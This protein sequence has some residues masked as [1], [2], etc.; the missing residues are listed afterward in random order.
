VD[1]A[2]PAVTLDELLTGRPDELGIDLDPDQ[3]RTGRRLV[4]LDDD[5]TGTQT[6]VDL[7]VLTSWSVEDLRWALEQPTAGFFVLVNTRSLSPDDAATRNREVV[8][9]LHRAAGATGI[10]YAIASRSDSTLRGYFPL[11]TDVLAEELAARGTAVDGVLVIPAYIEPGRVT[12]DSVHWTRTSDGMIPVAQSEFARDASFGYRSSDLRAW[13]A[14][15][16]G[17]RIA[18]ADVARITLDDIRTGGPDRVHAILT[19]LTGAAPVVV[20]AAADA[21]LRVVAAALVRAEAEGRTFLARIGPSFVRARVG[22]RAAPPIDAERLRALAD[23]S[24]AGP[25]PRPASR[26][27]LVVV[28]SHVGQTTRQLDRLRDR[29]GIVEVELDVPSLLDPARRDRHLDELVER[30]AELLGDPGS[31]ADVVLR[32]SRV[33]VTGDDAAASLEIARSVSTASVRVVRDVVQRI[34]PTFVVAKGGITSSDTATEALGIRRA[35]VRGTLLPGIISLWE[36]VAGPARGIP[37]VVFPGNV[38]DDDALVA[39]V[40]ALQPLDE[41]SRD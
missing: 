1:D 19:S 39:V 8:E 21:D 31:A 20:D 32:T 26:H 37:Y 7:P 2:V 22:Q 17:G 13:V 40:T 38:G 16:S 12:L 9:T 29:G 4:V 11:E 35:W 15:K 28:G 14:E 27:G 41:P 33:L 23:R 10:G 5:P 6:S 34:R 25:D 18:A 3:V 30:V 36:P 24:D